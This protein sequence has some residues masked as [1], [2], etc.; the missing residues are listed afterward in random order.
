VKERGV[1]YGRVSDKRQSFGASLEHQDA[2]AA[3]W[4]RRFD[5]EL[6]RL[7][8]ESGESARTRK[9]TTLRTVMQYIHDQAL[10]GTPV[11]VF[12]VYDLS[13]FCR[14]L[15]DQLALKRE[16]AASGCRLESVTFKV[17]E[18]PEGR[19]SQ[20]SI[21]AANQLVSE[22]QGKKIRECMLVRKQQG[23]WPHPAPFGYRNR[24]A[25]DGSRKW[26][27][28]DPAAA[29]ALA[30]AFAAIARGEGPKAVLERATAS[31]LVSKSGKRIR[32]QEFR[33]TLANPI[34]AGRIRSPRWGL[35]VAGEHEPIVDS[36]TF[37]IV[38]DRLAG[39]GPVSTRLVDRPEFPLRGFTLCD[40][41]GKPLTA[42]WSR[43]KLGG[44][45]GYYF[46]WNAV[47]RQVRRSATALEREFETML[48]R[49]RM[50][51][52]DFALVAA[53]L[54]EIS[55]A[56]EAELGTTRAAAGR[57][58]LD[59]RKKRDRMVEAF[60]YDQA[61]DRPTYEAHLQR[62]DAEI[63]SVN[64]EL[65]RTAAS[66][67]SVEE[68]IALAKPILTAPGELWRRA[69][70]QEKRRL[71]A[72]IFPAGTRSTSEALRTP[73]TAHIYCL[74]KGSSMRKV[75]VVEQSRGDSNPLRDWLEKAAAAVANICAVERLAWG[76]ALPAPRSRW[77]SLPSSGSIAAPSRGHSTGRR[78]M[79]SS[80]SAKPC[81]STTPACWRWR[82]RM[83]SR[84]GG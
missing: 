74:Q 57:R 15:E 43:G 80:P 17:E 70:L 53:A 8:R 82:K 50:E 16:L 25:D 79:P 81:R 35:D 52:G 39:R 18:T 78:C 84:S 36:G 40:A 67:L 75:K 77:T 72:L 42:S 11:D 76:T 13:R 3:D 30:A 62:L 37:A 12:L 7:F 45:Y 31:G 59:L 38:Q 19:F 2:A 65:S 29:P 28:P 44:R 9:R 32:M 20:N 47:C 23:R 4:C 41:C 26:I 54:A 5:I 55:K 58:L 69:E 51:E 27:E 60:V 22:L 1:F 83:P 48:G 63:H 73:E 71:Q 33:K 24:H 61:V 10:A 64:L 14:N 46:C 21:G 34:Y 56:D 68:L 49:L 6:V 66:R